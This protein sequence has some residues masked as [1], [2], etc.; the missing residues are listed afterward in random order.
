MILDTD[1]GMLFVTSEGMHLFL[2]TDVRKT[3]VFRGT[4]LHNSQKIISESH[5]LNSISFL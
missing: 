2:I 1:L 5:M 3:Y 4:G